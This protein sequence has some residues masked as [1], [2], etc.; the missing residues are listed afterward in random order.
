MAMRTLACMVWL[1]LAGQTLAGGAVMLAD[2][3]CLIRVGFY[4]V[5][6]TAYQPETRGD[7]GFCEAL[8]DTGETLLV[9]DYLHDSLREVPVELRVIRDATELGR[10]AR[11]EDVRALGDL[12]EHTVFHR[13]GVVEPDGSYQATHGFTEPGSY[14][15]IITAGHPTEDKRYTAVLP[16]TVGLGG[17][18]YLWI[19][20]MALLILGGLG[21]LGLRRY[22]GP[23]SSRAVPAR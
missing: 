17:L 4:D 7:E 13:P 14:L 2:N 11:L 10:F 9:L 23:A 16:F 21:W 12:S 3:P 6:F 18:G 8:P 1:L 15:A 22:S 5:H 20:A 19:A